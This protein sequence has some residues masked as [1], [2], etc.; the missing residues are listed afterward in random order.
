MAADEIYQV[1]FKA[2]V[3]E[4]EAVF[5][6][7]RIQLTAGQREF[8]VSNIAEV[9]RRSAWS[10]STEARANANAE[11]LRDQFTPLVRRAIRGACAE[12]RL[13]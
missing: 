1:L 8:L 12:M 10:Y 7:D 9:C 4:S 2:S 11:E 5:R 3:A 6:E 13:N